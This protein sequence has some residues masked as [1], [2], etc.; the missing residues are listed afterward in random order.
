MEK[1]VKKPVFWVIG[2]G[3]AVVMGLVVWEL[4][5]SRGPSF[6]VVAAPVPAA[7]PVP[8]PAAPAEAAVVLP[9]FDIVRINPKGD[10]VMAGRAAPGAELVLRDGAQDLGRAR[11]D[12]R[13][14][15]VFL[16]STPLAPGARELQVVERAANG[17]ER[18]SGGSVLVVVP[19]PGGANAGTAPLAVLS[20]D[21][22]APR[23][24]Q[25]PPE[26]SPAAGST[27]LGVDALDYDQEGAVRFA[28]TAA[29]GATVRVYV[30]NAPVGEAVADAGGRWTLAP[31][32][33]VA[34]GEHRLRADQVTAGGQVAGRVELP[35]RREARGLDSEGRVVVQPGQSLWLLARQAYGQGTRYTVIYAANKDHIRDPRLIYPGQSFALPPRP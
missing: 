9:S 7:S 24:L 13:G 27:K 11:A 34:E 33:A 4:R 16:P 19:D 22:A 23:L 28:G 17:E 3:L 21:S 8:V 12:A 14:N 35:F 5:T 2:L 30:D 6:P 32:A 10:A 25:G 31:S 15:W 26:T 20:S 18:K 29:P 1:T